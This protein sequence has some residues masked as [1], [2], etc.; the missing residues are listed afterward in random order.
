MTNA[1]KKAVSHA[2]HPDNKILDVQTVSLITWLI[3]RTKRA[4]PDFKAYDSWPNSDGN[5]DLIEPTVT[6]KN[7]VVGF[8]QVQ[9]KKLPD[10]Q[11][12]PKH[13]FKDDKFLNYCKDHG[14]VYPIILIGVNTKNKIAY[15]EHINSQ[16]VNS[17]G[18]KRII[19]FDK[20]KIIDEN[21]AKFVD[22]W[23]DVYSQYRNRFA[24]YLKLKASYDD[25]LNLVPPDY[26]KTDPIFIRIHNFLDEYNY[27]LDYQF[28]TIKSRFYPGAWKIGFAYGKYSPREIFYALYPIPFNKNDIQIKKIDKNLSKRIQKEADLIQMFSQENPIESN[29]K[30]HAKEIIISKLKNLIEERSLNNGTNQFLATEFVFA[31]I[32]KFNIPLGLENKNEYNLSEI[33][34]GFY[35]YLPAWVTESL[36]ILTTKTKEPRQNFA[37][38]Y[39]YFDPSILL[40]Q[41]SKGERE[42]I[43]IKLGDPTVD[44][45]LLRRSWPVGNS[46]LGFGLF[47]EML[48][49]LRNRNTDETEIKRIY[50]KRD[51]SENSRL[52]GF[53]KEDLEF[54]SEKLLT[55][56]PEVY[57]DFI[58]A[59][60]PSLEKDFSLFDEATSLLYAMKFSQRGD[61][62]Q[63]LKLFLKLQAGKEPQKIY[64]TFDNE[65]FEEYKTKLFQQDAVLTINNSSY[66]VLFH[67]SG[68]SSRHFFQSDT[69][70]LDLIYETIL[71]RVKKYSKK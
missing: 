5:I 71:E 1:K 37:V 68:H 2:T 60:F 55:S 7:A 31:F 15:W 65:A 47:V 21:S 53:T 32:D 8:L 11:K 10:K 12:M 70:M 6:P 33:V 61:Y 17:L 63:T 36:N 46:N 40:S 57:R 34:K 62:D 38:K 45:S 54:N 58:K 26:G 9:I 24:D 4:V 13:Y 22:D 69:P 59:N 25:L 3:S 49:Y 20:N 64:V 48:D 18:G 14:D 23:L 19:A 51:S 50:K 41:L 42:Q 67:G 30:N 16:Y 29:P 28:T 52:D 43:A 66:N 39:G 44:Y 56:F 27:L 35:E